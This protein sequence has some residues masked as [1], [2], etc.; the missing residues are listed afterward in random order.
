[1][2]SK[3][4]LATLALLLGTALPALAAQPFGQFGGKVGG[5][6]VGTGP[7]SIHGWALDDDGVEAV[8]I[9]VD[10]VVV[11]RAN[12]GRSRPGVTQKFPGFP[13]SAAPGFA[14]Q[15]DTTAY[16]NGLHTITAQVRSH[17]GEVVRLQSRSFQFQNSPYQL[18][19]IGAIEFPLAG[20]EMLGACNSSPNRR[21]SVVSGYA[22][23]FGISE[24]DTGVDAVELFID[25]VMIKHSKL[26]CHFDPAKGGQTNCY[27]I[28]RQDL[29]KIFPYFA[30]NPHIGWRFA[31]DVG[32]LIA[33][34]VSPGGHQLK[35]RAV[36]HGDQ[37]RDIAKMHVFLGCHDFLGNEESFG[38]T[39][40]PS[41]VLPQAGVVQFR[42]WALD[43]EGVL[44]VAVFVDGELIGLATYGLTR[45]DVLALYP[46]YPNSL[47]PGWRINVD[48]R[49]LSNG[50]HFLELRVRDVFNNETYVGHRRFV[51]ANP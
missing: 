50:E 25:G 2:R 1:M 10:G 24:D 35:I 19:P 47:A 46:G 6:T 45:P 4:T 36:D 21:Y 26:D 14:F 34:G 5:G 3:T 23:D 32:E 11:A 17:S 31:L 41:P 12:Y 8:D 44:D 33:R 9:L 16:P 13:D 42:G 48:T 20:V 28:R 7:M 30:N 43:W 49:L 27:G 29:V 38:F 37:Y 18:K 39:E 22:Y 40:L 51:V 15:I